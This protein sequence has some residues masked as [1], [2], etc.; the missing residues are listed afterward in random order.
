M[1]ERIGSQTGKEEEEQKKY[2]LTNE[3]FDG[4]LEAIRSMNGI[5]QLQ[6][7]NKRTKEEGNRS[8][9]RR[10]KNHFVKSGRKCME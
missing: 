10:T 9:H 5:K 3:G 6:N 8:E 1:E 4:A 2:L 7:A